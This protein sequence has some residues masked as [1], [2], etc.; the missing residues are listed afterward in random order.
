LFIRFIFTLSYAPL[1]TIRILPLYVFAPPQHFPLRMK[2]NRTS[3]PLLTVTRALIRHRSCN[4][5]TSINVGS[6]PYLAHGCVD[7]FFKTRERNNTR[8]CALKQGNTLF[9]CL[10]NKGTTSFCTRFC[11]L[12][13]GNTFFPCLTN[14]GTTCSLVVK[15]AIYFTS[16]APECIFYLNRRF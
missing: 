4:N 3:F 6:D 11:E 15:G 10:T 14:K 8:F 1:V 9:P 5:P 7:F 12:K 16:S 13:Q 2:F